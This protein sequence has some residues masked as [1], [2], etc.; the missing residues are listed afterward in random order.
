MAS[1]SSRV[2]PMDAAAQLFFGEASEPAF[3]QVE[4]G[5]ARRRE[6]EM[7][8]RMTQQPTLDGRGFLVGGVV[9]DDQMECEAAR[10]LL[11]N[12]LQ[13]LAELH[14]PMAAMKLPDH[15]ARLE[16]ER[17]EQVGS[18]VTQ[19]VGSTP[20]SLAGAHR[21]QRL[22]AIECL[23]LALLV[24]AQHQ[25]AV[26]R[27]EVKPDDIAHFLDE[28]RVFGKLEA[29]DSMRLQRKGPP[30][31]AH[32]ALTQAAALGHR[33]RAPVRGVRGRALQSHAHHPLNLCVAHLA[34]GARPR[35]IEQTCQPPSRNRWRHLP[36]VW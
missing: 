17:G 31:A 14:R 34:R 5:R 18:A 29:L 26:R 9:V 20:L 19:I 10:D 35:L 11:V 28:Q 21:Q 6:V 32:H 12:R 23:D 1:C 16:V 15:G 3:H 7:K 13:K 27:I 30:D 2:L 25:R 24:D 33:A 22:T 8:A 36:T 4:P